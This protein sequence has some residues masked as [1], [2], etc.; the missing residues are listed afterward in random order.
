LKVVPP[1]ISLPIQKRKKLRIM[2]LEDL[3]NQYTNC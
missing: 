2:S 1:L 3:V